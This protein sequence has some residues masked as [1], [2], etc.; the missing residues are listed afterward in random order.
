VLELSYLEEEP[1]YGPETQALVAAGARL[2]ELILEREKIVSQREEARTTSLALQETARQ[3]DAF[4]GMATHEL[5]TPLTA[6]LL[7]LQVNRRRLEHLQL[8]PEEFT[9]SVGEQLDVIVAEQVKLE[10]QAKR[11]DRLVNDL[12]DLSR[13]QAGKL[14]MHP[15]PTDL[16]AMVQRAVQEQQQATP[17]RTIQL[18]QTQL[19]QP[20]WVQADAD[21]VQQATL[22]Y[23]TN[24]LKYSPADQPVEVGVDIEG[25]RVRVWVRDHGPGLTEAAQKRLWQRYYR[26][27][28][29]EVQSGTGVGLGLGLMIVRQIVEL[30]GGEVGVQSA[31]GQGST[32]WFT[33]PLAETSAT[34]TTGS[35]W[36]R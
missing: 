11:L 23:L 24:A 1:A 3:M 19:E 6:I 14:Q 35:S 20:V 16:T 5:K 28:G 31:P 21:R 15:E 26:V 30:H 17:E 34:G 12:V 8:R 2:A 18:R 13:V 7:A 9:V 29:I 10:S 36:S 22:N 33:L 4:L 32:F 27:P 25:P